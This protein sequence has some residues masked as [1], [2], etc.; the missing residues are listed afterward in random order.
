MISELIRDDLM[1]LYQTKQYQPIGEGH[2]SKAP[3]GMMAHE[4]KS[5][6]QLITQVDQAS[7]EELDQLLQKLQYENM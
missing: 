6:T 2:R 4:A 5:P 7:K 3:L 1:Y